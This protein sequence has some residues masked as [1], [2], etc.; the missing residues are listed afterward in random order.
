MVSTGL[1]AIV[2]KGLQFAR[3][4]LREGISVKRVV[5]ALVGW[6][7]LLDGAPGSVPLS[8]QQLPTFRTGVDVVQI[9]VSVLDKDRRPVRGLTAADFTV[10]EDGKPRPV[11]AFSAIEL[12]ALPSPLPA[13][14]A[15]TVPPDVVRN[16][17]PDGRLVVILLD[18]FL[19]RVMVPGRVTMADPPGLTALRNTALRV[20]DS[21]GPG[22]LA[23]VGHTIYG[24]MQNLTAD[25][26]RLKRAIESTAMGSVKRADGE[27][28]GSCECGVCRAEAIT[29]IATALAG[30]PQRRKAVFYVGERLRLSPVEG[31]C[32]HYLEPATKQLVQATQLAN[33]NVHTV[34][35]NSLET[36][37]VR[38]GDDFQPGTPG[39]VSAAAAAQEQK[40]RAFLIE[41]QQSL[42]TVADWTGGRAV[43]N[44]NAPEAS[45]RP[46][47]EESSAYYLLGFQT[48]DVKTDGRFHPIT[49]KVNRPDV[50]VRTRKGYYADAVT[51]AGRVPEG[52]VSLE[53]VSRG[54]LPER[55]LPLNV[56][57]AAFRGPAGT[58]VVMVTTG[59]RAGAAP[60]SDDKRAGGATPGQFEPIEILTSA[61]RDG[62]KDVEWGRQRLSVALPESAP[63]ELRYE[64]VSTLNLQP[65]V[66]ELRVATR[67]EQSGATGSVH[68]YVDVPDFDHESLTLSGVVLFD[69]RAPTATPPE[70]LAGI[71]DTAPTTRREFGGED[72]VSGLVRVYRRQGE[73]PAPVTVAFRV[74]DSALHEV[75]QVQT[76]LTPDQFAPTGAAD[77]RYALPLGALLP[78]SYVLRVEM[79]TARR[80]VRF[81]RR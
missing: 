68:T 57:T 42:Q 44:T 35:P 81:T 77:A 11:V 22:D 71:L 46:I 61:F 49:V 8:A 59:V 34:D 27:E 33:V 80:D 31:R 72:T 56:A 66:Y 47:L 7:V 75:A 69:R 58:P 51:A 63:G 52:A 38:A 67:H 45:V 73:R 6:L 17:A 70:A 79:G 5:I 37:N 4:A 13:G 60:S 48:S 12:P 55:G 19:E 36:T 15:D 20:V 29:K 54:L 10:L 41:R 23:A 28:W 39:S 76:P 26:S 9:D 30:E 14:S 62:K 2:Q 18:P 1:I 16:D 25:K 43:M 3:P 64:A 78:G 40:N 24:V 50:Q 53:A 21:L 65:G 32:N 74:L